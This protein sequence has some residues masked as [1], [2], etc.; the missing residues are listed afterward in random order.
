MHLRD[1]LPPDAV[2]T[3]GAGNYTVWVHRYHRHRRYGVQLAPTSGAMGYGIPAAIAAKAVHPDR[4]AIAFAGDGCFMMACQELATAVQFDLPIIVVLADNGMLGTIRMHQERQF[5]GRI[6]GTSL[7][8]PDFVALARSFGCHAE[9]VTDDA[10]F[11]P[12]AGT[13]ARRRNAGA[14]PPRLRSPGDHACNDA[15][16]PRRQLLTPQVV[17]PILTFTPREERDG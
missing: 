15:R 6:S 10:G 12:G 11:P 8:N 1:A 3:N 9:Q 4:P 17:R 7:A 14:H 13:R 16:R 2:I 5:P